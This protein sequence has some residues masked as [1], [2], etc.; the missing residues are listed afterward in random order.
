MTF[1]KKMYQLQ[2]TFAWTETVSLPELFLYSSKAVESKC[3]RANFLLCCLFWWSSSLCYIVVFLL[4]KKKSPR[5][6]QACTLEKD[7][8]KPLQYETL[9]WT[10]DWKGLTKTTTL[11]QYRPESR[12]KKTTIYDSNVSDACFDQYQNSSTV[13]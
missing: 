10:Q 4:N 12:T 13:L 1:T 7:Q 5:I 6:T 8:N 11:K 9:I 3:D 2:G